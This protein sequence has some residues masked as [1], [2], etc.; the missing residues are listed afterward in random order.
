[1]R[2]LGTKAARVPLYALLQ[3]GCGLGSASSP[4]T[5]PTPIHVVDAQAAAAACNRFGFDLYARATVRDANLALSP[6]SAATALAMAA[7]G[8]RGETL[9]QMSRVLHVDGLADAQSTFAALLVS[10]SGKAEEPDAGDE[11]AGVPR[12][13]GGEQLPELA[14]A[15]RIWAQKGSSYRAEFLTTLRIQYRASLGQVDFI[16]EAEAARS[17]INGW[18]TEQTRGRIMDLLAPGTVDTETRLVLTNA[19]YFK[20]K[21]QSPFLLGA[22]H[23]EKFHTPTG[24]TPARMMCQEGSFRHAHLDDVQL[25]EL[26]Y[27]GARLSMIVVL[28]DS[29]NGLGDAERRIGQSYDRWLAALT[30]KTVNLWLPR[31][32]VTQTVAM[33]DHLQAMGMPLAFKAGASGADFSGMSDQDAFYIG[34]VI[35]KVFVDS[36]ETGTEA[37]AATA[38]VTFHFVDDTLDSPPPPVVFHADHPFLYVIRDRK[39]G[40][41]LFLGRVVDPG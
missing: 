19:V 30:V 32:T 41:A 28:P 12:N 23:E 34:A 3:V 27:T 1:M 18:V 9:A 20:G 35:Q 16:S 38:V 13:A 24:P 6:L 36:S 8:A 31:W 11:V 5:D 39:T 2:R 10:L 17:E 26:P 4:S 37:A 29:T 22:T 25:V 33:A 21:W 40:A 14:I 15:D 7:A